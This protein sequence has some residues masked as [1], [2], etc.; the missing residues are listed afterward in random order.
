MQLGIEVPR[1][2]WV[3]DSVP[4]GNY[5][6]VP[7]ALYTIIKRETF[8]G[9]Y[10]GYV[11]NLITGCMFSSIQ[12]MLYEEFVTCRSSTDVAF[13][14]LFSGALSGFLT[15]P[16]DV[17]GTRLM[18]QGCSYGEKSRIIK[19]GYLESL[20]ELTSREGFRGLFRGVLPRVLW[21]APF[22]G[23]SFMLYEYSKCVLDGHYMVR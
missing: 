17:I 18:V 9:L 13:A 8:F 6:H 16:F 15:N 20:F 7:H 5:K 2:R 1:T 14:G 21:C 10:S 11:A 12:F 23:L 22:S 19:F 3:R 4:R